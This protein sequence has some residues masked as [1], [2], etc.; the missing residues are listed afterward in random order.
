MQDEDYIPPYHIKFLLQNKHQLQR[1]CVQAYRD[2]QCIQPCIQY[3]LQ[4]A[5][6]FADTEIQPLSTCFLLMLL[7]ALIVVF[8]L[9][10]KNGYA[11]IICYIDNPKCFVPVMPF[12]VPRHCLS[13]FI[14][15]DSM[16][17]LC[18]ISRSQ[19]NMDTIFAYM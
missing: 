15:S 8:F 16:C 11:S 6:T 4:D 2:L 17:K 5:D 9:I 14:K 12:Y 18:A 7:L 3:S 1:C 10:M 19:Y 13:I